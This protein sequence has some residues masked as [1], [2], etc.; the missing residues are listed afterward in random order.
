MKK[1]ELKETLGQIQPSEALIRTTLLKVEEQRRKNAKPVFAWMGSYGYRYAAAVCTLVLLLGI[2]FI[3]RDVSGNMPMNPQE[4]V[5]SRSSG[6]DEA[7]YGDV[8]IAAYTSEDGEAVP[9]TKGVLCACTMCTVSE[10]EKAS[11]IVAHAT[12]L[13]EQG[14][15]ETI[16]AEMYFYDETVLEKLVAAVSNELYFRLTSEECEDETMWKVLDFSTE[17]K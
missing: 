16:R 7:D 9:W 13:L 4:N 15:G 12:L 6:S 1:E 11:G 3:T 8:Q 5:A 10:E 2:G 17:E 14:D